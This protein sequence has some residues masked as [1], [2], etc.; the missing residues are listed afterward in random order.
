MP[1]Q[2]KADDTRTA[3]GNYAFSFAINNDIPL[4]IEVA[5]GPC[6]EWQG[7]RYRQGYGQKSVEGKK[8]R[9][10]RAVW[11]NA[12]GPIPPGFEIMHICNNPPCYRLSHLRIGTHSENMAHMWMSGRGN[13]G[14]HN[15]RLR[16]TPKTRQL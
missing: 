11:E 12:N 9:L 2:S 16:W 8:V 14:P 3:G 5:V 7:T 10:H 4:P 13:S 6:E 15:G 1:S